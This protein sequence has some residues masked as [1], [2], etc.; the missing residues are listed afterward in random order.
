M[1]RSPA[2]VGREL[3]RSCAQGARFSRCSKSL[4][5][6]TAARCYANNSIRWVAMDLAV[7]AE[8]LIV[9]PLYRVRLRLNWSP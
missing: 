5:K 9:V 7:M 3:L 8:G 4:K 1:A 6:A 2:S